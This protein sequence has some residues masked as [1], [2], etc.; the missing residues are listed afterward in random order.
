MTEITQERAER[1]ARAHPCDHCGEYSFKSLKVKRAS[2]FHHKALGEV[3][4]VIKTCGVCGMHQEVGI[5]T[6]GDIVYAT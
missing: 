5:D 6:E 1:I 2:E 4:H 3:W